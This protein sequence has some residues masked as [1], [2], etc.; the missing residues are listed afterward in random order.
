MTKMPRALPHW[1]A[2]IVAA[3][4]CARTPDPDPVILSF[5]QG[6]VRRSDFERHVAALEARGGHALSG[7]VRRAIVQ[8]FVEEK[9]LLL[10]ARERGLVEAVATAEQEAMAV[11]RLLSA[12][13][14]SGVSVSDDE[15]RRAY[16]EEQGKWQQA[17][18]VR[19]RQ[20]LVPTENQARDVVRRL[21]RN[22]R[23]F[24]ILARTLSHG[25]EASQGGLMGSYQPGE[26]PT[27]LEGPAFSL[28]VGGR[29][30][31]IR[32]SLGFHVLRVEGREPRRD[33]SVE[34]CRDEIRELVARRKADDAVRRFVADLLARAKVN[35]EAA[36]PVRN[37]T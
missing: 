21:R 27:E 14:L 17:E 9:I 8:P 31:V 3:T 25:P 26:L 10:E 13:V 23:D 37:P 24:E 32:S 19:L 5:A 20:I 33:R 4:A 1:L 12:E 7:E 30:D 28:P 6:Q 15:I 35:Y 34:E 16:A 2:L 11:E 18:R 22:P 36:E 29:S